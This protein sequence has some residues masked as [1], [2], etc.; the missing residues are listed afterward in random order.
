MAQKAPLHIFFNS[1][2]PNM[3]RHVFFFTNYMLLARQQH[4]RRTCN[5]VTP[6]RGRAPLPPSIGALFIRFLLRPPYCTYMVGI[7]KFASLSRRYAT[8]REVEP[9]TF[10]TPFRGITSSWNWVI[11][12]KPKGRRQKYPDEVQ[13]PQW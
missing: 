6:V 4:L 8:W 10:R 7:W 11:R 2:M 3:S 1:K 9:S 12:S 5:K 13:F